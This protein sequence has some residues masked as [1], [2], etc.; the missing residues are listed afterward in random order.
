MLS[1]DNHRI[2][3]L[4]SYYFDFEPTGV[5]EVDLILGAICWAG[6]AYHSTACWPDE[7]CDGGPSEID[8]IQKAANICAAAMKARSQAG[9]SRD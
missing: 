8:N 3:K 2:E 4:D 7:G 9:G 5:P 6:K 1:L